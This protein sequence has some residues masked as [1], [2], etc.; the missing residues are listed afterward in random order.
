MLVNAL[1][2][3]GTRQ[4]QQDTEEPLDFVPIPD[5]HVQ[6]GCL[7]QRSDN[8]FDDF[9][10]RLLELGNGLTAHSLILVEHE[11]LRRAMIGDSLFE[12]C[13]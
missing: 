11:S 7:F 5:F 4:P 6:H 1:V 12:P 10:H 8:C 3:F 2:F 9:F 13:H